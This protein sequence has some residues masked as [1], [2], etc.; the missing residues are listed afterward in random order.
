[1]T[2]QSEQLILPIEIR[3]K[4]E[5]YWFQVTQ[6]K[7]RK[8]FGE[9]VV[10]KLVIDPETGMPATTV[11]DAADISTIQDSNL[12]YALRYVDAAEAIGWVQE[13]PGIQSMIGVGVDAQGDGVDAQFV[14]A[15]YDGHS[16]DFENLL[17]A[18]DP[19]IHENH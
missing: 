6:E 14:S 1:M 5:V 10:S 12:R 16:R 11:I 2:A 17:H 4:R 15:Q 8:L 9:R 13:A 7:R 19:R 3:P 18:Q